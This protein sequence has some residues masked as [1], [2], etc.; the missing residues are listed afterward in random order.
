MPACLFAVTTLTCSAEVAMAWY[1]PQEWSAPPARC[2]MCPVIATPITP[3]SV[4]AVLEMPLHSQQAQ[5]SRHS[6]CYE[7]P[8]CGSIKEEA[9]SAS[10]RAYR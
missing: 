2:S 9:Q 10:A 7:R 3:D 4:P 1:Q 5:R 8:K 6:A